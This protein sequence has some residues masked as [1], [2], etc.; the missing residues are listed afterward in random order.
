MQCTDSSLSGSVKEPCRDDTAAGHYP[1]GD[2][3]S[4]LGLSRGFEFKGGNGTRQVDLDAVTE[5][6]ELGIFNAGKDCHGVC[7]LL[8]GRQ[9]AEAYLLP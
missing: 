9:A 5:S 2:D 3:W 7:S 6:G 4:T 8:N 1:V